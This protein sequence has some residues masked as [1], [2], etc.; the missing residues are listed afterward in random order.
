MIQQIFIILSHMAAF[1]IAQLPIIMVVFYKRLNLGY[2]YDYQSMLRIVPVSVILIIVSAYK[3]IY[4]A[5]YSHKPS[6]INVNISLFFAI[7][8]IVCLFLS[9]YFIIDR[10]ILH[11]K[12]K[13]KKLILNISAGLTI[14]LS[15]FTIFQLVFQFQENNFNY[16]DMAINFMYPALTGILSL[17]GIISLIFYKRASKSQK[18]YSFIF[19]FSIPLLLLDIIF[20]GQKHFMLTSIAYIAYIIE[21]FIEVFSSATAT[22]K[23]KIVNDS[24]DTEFKKQYDLTDREIEVYVLAAQGLSNHEISEKLFVSV[25]TVKTHLQHI[26][27][28]LDIST[29]YQLI[30]FYNERENN[31]K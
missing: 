24:E 30:N 27:S 28:K 21:I 20:A 13:Q 25:H 12:R 22:N 11:F 3:V 31:D 29:R 23:N 15:I 4:I 1:A 19:V 7:A 2:K 10:A 9:I 5:L 8:F 14:L 16:I 17:A 18:I 6:S 26:F